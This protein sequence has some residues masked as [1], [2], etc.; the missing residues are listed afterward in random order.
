LTPVLGI[1]HQPSHLAQDVLKQ[2]GLDHD[3]I[4]PCFSCPADLGGTRLGRDDENRDVRSRSVAAQDFAQLVAVNERQDDFGDDERRRMHQG[5]CEGVASIRRFHDFASGEHQRLA[6]ERTRIS[7][8]VHEEDRRWRR[9][10]RP[11]ARCSFVAAV[12]GHSPSAESFVELN[13]SGDR[14]VGHRS[15]AVARG[16]ARSRNTG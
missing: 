16:E 1:G 11:Y 10:R 15:A 9:G 13:P 2:C 4:G 3:G 14:A 12:H 6:I 7:V 5:F 8:G